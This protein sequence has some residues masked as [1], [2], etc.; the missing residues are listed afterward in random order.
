M[1]NHKLALVVRGID[2]MNDRVGKGLSFLMLGLIFAV[3]FEVIMRYV[4]DAP[5]KWAPETAQLI[6]AT[7]AVMLGAYTHL[8]G[9]HVNVDIVNNRLPLRARAILDLCTS[10]FFFFFCSVMLWLGV[11]LAAESIEIWEHSGSALASPIWAI[12]LMI[13]LAAFLIILQEVARFIRNITIATSGKEL[14]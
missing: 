7:Y 9:I 11:G 8:H 14:E 4:F 6:F 12:K 13:P 2:T 3:V 10:I 5:T 1:H